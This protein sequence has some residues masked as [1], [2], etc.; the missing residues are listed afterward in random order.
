MSCSSP[1]TITT[2]FSCHHT[3]THTHT[4]LIVPQTPLL[5]IQ[6]PEGAPSLRLLSDAATAHILPPRSSCC[7]CVCGVLDMCTRCTY[8]I[9]AQGYVQ[10]QQPLPQ[11][12]VQ[13][14]SVLSADN[15]SSTNLYIRGLPQ[16]CTDED[17]VKMCS[18]CVCVCV[19]VPVCVCVCVCACVCVCV[20]VCL[21]VCVSVHNLHV[22]T[23][24]WGVCVCV[25]MWV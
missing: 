13:Q 22:C 25:Y 18:R 21:C 11:S 1:H 16:T 3:H 9:V 5:L 8:Q 23:C 2:S 4:H 19:C 15:L 20:C 24:L 10:A 12:R 17:L 7:E 14:A 6:A